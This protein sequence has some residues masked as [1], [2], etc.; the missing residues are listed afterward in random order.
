M[1]DGTCTLVD[2]P[3]INKCQTDPLLSLVDYYG[4]CDSHLSASHEFK[5]WASDLQCQNDGLKLQCNLILIV[6]MICQLQGTFFE[7]ALTMTYTS[8]H[9]FLHTSFQYAASELCISKMKS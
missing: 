6:G 8:S 3:F 9:Q 2:K 4:R 1:K 5:Q 7:V